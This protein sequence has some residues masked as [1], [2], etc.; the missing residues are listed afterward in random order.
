MEIPKPGIFEH[1]DSS[2]TK[3]HKNTMNE[4]RYGIPYL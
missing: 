2:T 1:Y 4:G 3:K